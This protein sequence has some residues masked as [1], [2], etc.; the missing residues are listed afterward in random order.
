LL[1]PVSRMRMELSILILIYEVHA[2]LNSQYRLILIG[3]SVVAAPPKLAP[4]IP[5]A[6]GTRGQNGPPSLTRRQLPQPGKG[7]RFSG[8]SV[9]RRNGSDLPETGKECRR[10]F[11]EPRWQIPR[12]ARGWNV[13]ASRADRKSRRRSYESSCI[14][15]RSLSCGWGEFDRC[16]FSKMVLTA[17]LRLVCRWRTTVEPC[18]P[19][20]FSIRAIR[21]IRG[22]SDTTGW[23]GSQSQM[24]LCAFLRQIL[25]GCGPC[26]TGSLPFLSIPGFRAALRSFRRKTVQPPAWR[27]GGRLKEWSRCFLT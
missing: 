10:P 12:R 24:P 8:P 7:A 27:T 4:T 19:A 9:S 5:A 6:T 20:P 13:P 26:R 23:P 25:F 1:S 2:G 21:A 14:Q 15:R 16:P 17:Y 11:P 3:G 22:P 18:A